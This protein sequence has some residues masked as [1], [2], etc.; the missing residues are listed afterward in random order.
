[1]PYEKREALVKVIRR[2]RTVYI[3][4]V[5]MGDVVL[6]KPG[7]AIPCDGTLRERRLAKLTVPGDVD[8][9]RGPQ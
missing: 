8:N 4:D 5:A 6:F 2:G 7:E 1:M 3:H 9:T